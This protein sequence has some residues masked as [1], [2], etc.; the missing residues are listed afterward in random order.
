MKNQIVV[1]DY[2]TIKDVKFFEVV[3]FSGLNCEYGHREFIGTIENKKYR[4]YLNLKTNCVYDLKEYCEEVKGGLNPFIIKKSQTDF[5]RLK[6][7]GV[8]KTNGKR[9][10]R[11]SYKLEV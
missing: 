6:L 8:I 9:N 11:K 4:G 10:K 3:Y 1:N 5:K 2:L 7:K